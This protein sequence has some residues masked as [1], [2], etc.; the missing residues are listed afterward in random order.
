MAGAVLMLV[1]SMYPVAPATIQP[2]VNEVSGRQN[3]DAMSM[4]S[5]EKPTDETDYDG[6][7]AQEG[8]TE[9]LGLEREEHGV[10]Q[11]GQFKREVHRWDWAGSR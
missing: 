10:H 5:R 1:E 2:T 7:V 8:T 3:D 6:T 4:C 11:V 9:Y